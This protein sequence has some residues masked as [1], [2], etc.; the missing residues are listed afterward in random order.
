MLRFPQQFLTPLDDYMDE[1]KDRKVQ[2][3]PEVQVRVERA[4]DNTSG[5]VFLCERI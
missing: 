4:A 1:E 5:D 2:F 3:E